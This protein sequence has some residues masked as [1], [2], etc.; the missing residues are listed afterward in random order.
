MRSMSKLMV[1]VL[2]VFSFNFSGNSA[3]RDSKAVKARFS[4]IF[5]RLDTGGDV[6]LVANIE[7]I[8]EETIDQILSLATMVTFE[9]EE[10][11]NKIG[12]LLDKAAA[13]L[14][15]NGFTPRKGLG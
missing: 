11:R 7:G 15:K 12:E 14:E 13:F 6:L 10:K 8:V 1:L 4:E 2:L 9:T 5:T 3:K